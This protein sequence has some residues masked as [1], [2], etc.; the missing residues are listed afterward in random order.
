MSI[1]ACIPLVIVDSLVVVDNLPLTDEFTI[2]RGD[3]TL[4]GICT[5][6]WHIYRTFA[7]ISCWSHYF[8]LFLW[9]HHFLKG[10]CKKFGN[11]S[12]K[13]AGDAMRCKKM[14][15]FN[16][17]LIFRPSSQE[18]EWKQIFYFLD[19]FEHCCWGNT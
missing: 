3:C 9:S 14:L 12:I 4:N 15:P 19:F 11:P 2:T 16:F 8:L 6:H 10:R 13:V 5:K 17:A 18:C 1:L 7:L